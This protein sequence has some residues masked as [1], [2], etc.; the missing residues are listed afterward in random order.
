MVIIIINKFGFFIFN[1]FSKDILFFEPTSVFLTNP[2]GRVNAP[3]VAKL[4]CRARRVACHH[5]HK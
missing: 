5:L 4:H 2:F 1:P 3:S